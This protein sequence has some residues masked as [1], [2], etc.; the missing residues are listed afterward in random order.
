M[1]KI[2]WVDDEIEFL[3]PHI[4]LLKE[5]GHQVDTA[6]NGED[7][8][9]LAA[10]KNFDIVFLD[11]MMPGMDGLSVLEKL[12]T[13]HPYVKVVMVTKSEEESLMEEAIG[14]KIDDYLTKPVNPSQILM[15]IKKQL[16]SAEISQRKM[17]MNTI[18][19]IREIS[20][21]LYDV[22][23]PSDWI[24]IFNSL[25]EFEVELDETGE[26]NIRESFNDLRRECNTEFCK[27]IEKNYEKWLNDDETEAPITSVDIVKNFVYPQLEQNNQVLFVVIDCLRYDQW[28]L[29]EKLLQPFFDIQ[30]ENYFSILPTAT[31]FSRNSLFSGLWPD[32][33]H[34]KYSDIYSVTKTGEKGAN[35]YERQMLDFQIR[36]LGYRPKADIKYFKVFSNDE[37]KRVKDNIQAI[38]KSDISALVVNSVDIIAHSRA[39]TPV[40]KEIAPN[41]KAY[42]E[43]TRTWFEH[44]P[45]FEFFKE[46]SRTGVKIVLTSD[47]GS[48]RVLK[49]AKVVA[50]KET[51][52]NLRYKFGRNLKVDKKQAIKLKN[53]AQYR[54]PVLADNL[55]FIIAKEDYYFV[56]PTKFNY[57]LA[58]YK[59]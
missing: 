58:Q 54:L 28:L 48:I 46:L 11:E 12:K 51:S 10:E 7:A 37:I 56:Y 38:I 6:Y 34:N 52:V 21:K 53:P 5:K 13:S 30:K 33:I 16:Q 8:L 50:D 32:E 4:L 40:L 55:D 44:S 3:K 20:E 43:L 26:E 59:D 2:L 1:A 9:A 24:S 25:M 23:F 27:Y 17:T 45:L 35:Q 49:G 57:Y 42:R 31:P 15:A 47:H 39:D 29:M 22:Q 36:K 18:V 14:A 19:R 41:E